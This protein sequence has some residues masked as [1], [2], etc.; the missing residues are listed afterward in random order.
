MPCLLCGSEAAHFAEDSLRAYFRCPRCALIF[1]D[2]STHPS[3]SGEKARYD[4]HR[5]DPDDEG[6]RAY[7]DHLIEPMLARLRAGMKGLDYGCGP[8]RVLVSMLEEAGMVMSAYDPFYADDKR[9]LESQYDFVTCTEVVEHF[10]D[11]AREWKRLVGLVLP[12]GWLGIMT[13]LVPGG[14]PETFIRW[15]YRSDHTHLCFYSPATLRFLASR[16][17]LSLHL[18]D[19]NSAIMKSPQSGVCSL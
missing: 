1:A 17:R 5:N 12:G 6:Y 10:R 4:K 18:R 2:P 7:L 8:G 9:L 14:D 11:P 15:H 16:F 13:Q 19:T 3:L